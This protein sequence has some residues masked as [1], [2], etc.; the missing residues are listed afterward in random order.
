M[1]S[2]YNSLRRAFA[3]FTLHGMLLIWICP[4]LRLWGV[5]KSYNKHALKPL[6]ASHP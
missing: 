4:I 6:N 2:K 1:N 3:T 5:M